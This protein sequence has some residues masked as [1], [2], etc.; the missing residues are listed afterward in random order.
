MYQQISSIYTLYLLQDTLERTFGKLKWLAG[1]QKSF[2][3]LS[4]KRLLR[5]YILGCGEIIPQPKKSNVL[6][7]EPVHDLTGFEDATADLVNSVQSKGKVIVTTIT[8]AEDEMLDISDTELIHFEVDPI[9]DPDLESHY[10][11]ACGMTDI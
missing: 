11:E 8:E 5:N 1:S 9:D 3:A 10:F 6:P 7:E 2:G 4:F